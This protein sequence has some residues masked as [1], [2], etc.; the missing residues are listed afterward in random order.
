M[1][2]MYLIALIVLAPPIIYRTNSTNR[3]HC[4]FICS[5][6]FMSSVRTQFQIIRSKTNFFVNTFVGFC[7]LADVITRYSH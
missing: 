6:Y 7:R 5:G 1:E 2:Y 4:A 3:R